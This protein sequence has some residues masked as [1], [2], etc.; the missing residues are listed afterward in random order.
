MLVQRIIHYPAMG[1]AGELRAALE[2]R[3]KAANASGSPH[4]L[5]QRMFWIEPALV[6]N[7]RFDNLAAIE[8]YQAKNVNDAAF[9]EITGNI[10]SLLSRPQE[11]EL[12]ETLAT[13][14]ASTTP[15]F[16]LLV[17]RYPSL[18]KVSEARKILEARVDASMPGRIGAAMSAQVFPPDGPVIVMNHVFASMASIDEY[19]AAIAQAP[20]GLDGRN[21][22]LASIE[23]RTPQQAIYRIL[24]PFPA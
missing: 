23:R 11:T 19:R 2:E 7:I 5:T 20:G 16:A 3:S 14:P 13:K 4:S 24:Q 9:R 8:A 21:S 10:G 1:K 22:E 6:H 15:Q 18:D 12:F 17:R